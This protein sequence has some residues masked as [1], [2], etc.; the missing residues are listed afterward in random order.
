[1]IA[2]T[3]IYE[4]PS[5]AKSKGCPSATRQC[6]G[7]GCGAWDP[8]PEG[9]PA[10]SGRC[11]WK[12]DAGVLG[13]VGMLMALAHTLTDLPLTAPPQMLAL[14]LPLWAALSD[15]QLGLTRIAHRL[16]AELR[17]GDQNA[18]QTLLADINA[19]GIRLGAAGAAWGVG[20]SP[21]GGVGN[22]PPAKCTGSANPSESKAVDPGDALLGVD[23]APQYDI[24]AE[25]AE[26]EAQVRPGG[27][28][29]EAP[30]DVFN[31][32]RMP[33]GARVVDQ[34]DGR[35]CVILREL[36][37]LGGR[38]RVLVRYTGDWYGRDVRVVGRTGKHID[39]LHRDGRR[40]RVLYDLPDEGGQAV[41]R[42]TYESEA[43][44]EHLKPA[45]ILKGSG[46][47]T[48]PPSFCDGEW[49]RMRRGVGSQASLG[50][51]VSSNGDQYSVR[52]A[53]G[54]VDGINAR[55][56]TWVGGS[57]THAFED[58]QIV[59]RAT[60]PSVE[61]DLEGGAA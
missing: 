34:R 24:A 41:V 43:F 49:I 53:D 18:L 8:A 19:R 5:R 26:V 37:T 36:D 11:S 48:P 15:A 22:T 20:R 31:W 3:P 33:I 46:H 40:G 12:V 1:M 47:E 6:I 42:V 27:L 21:T 61:V 16:R 17:K 56:L 59:R 7:D 54:V 28:S 10:G 2:P 52:F 30:A 38:P 44:R 14:A 58:G 23:L 45:R 55:S 50:Q 57:K 35:A 9:W 32:L 60:A 4:T 51:V 13:E 25:W 29:T 39:V